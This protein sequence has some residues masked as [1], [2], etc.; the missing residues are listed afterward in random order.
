[1]D[2]EVERAG[3]I[4]AGMAL[5]MELVPDHGVRREQTP[6]MHQRRDGAENEQLWTRTCRSPAK[7]RSSARCA[8]I[9]MTSLACSENNFGRRPAPPRGR[10]RQ[11]RCL[12]ANACGSSIGRENTVYGCGK[13]KR[14]ARRR[15]RASRSG[16]ALDR[17]PRPRAIPR[18][19]PLVPAALARLLHGR[20]VRARKRAT[21]P[22]G[23]APGSPTK[24]RSSPF[25]PTRYIPPNLGATAG[26]RIARCILR[27]S[28][29]RTP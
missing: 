17:W 26:G 8:S 2:I 14:S 28:S 4:V 15:G 29:W 1:M 13:H 18:L 3:Q 20:R 27:W 16:R 21:R 11:T 7:S 22:I 25:R 10:K 12:H 24:D 6:E 9:R 5:E 23:A 19:R